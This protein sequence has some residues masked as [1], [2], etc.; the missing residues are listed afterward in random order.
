MGFIPSSS[1]IQLYAYFTE[2][3]RERIFNGEVSDFQV[4]QFSLHD[5]D[6][7][8]QISKYSLGQDSSG[9]TIYNIPKSGFI[10]DI[11]GDPDSCIKS[12]KN[13]IVFGKNMLT[14]TTQV[15]T[16]IVLGCTDP[17]ALNYDS[18]ATV[19]NGT[20]QYPPTPIRTLTIGFQDVSFKELGPPSNLKNHSYTF[21]VNLKALV[22]DTSGGPTLAESQATT[23]KIEILEFDPILVQNITIV[24]SNPITFI[25]G[26]VISCDL[27]F[28][29]SNLN[30]TGEPNYTEDA[31]IKIK[32]TPISPNRTVETGKGTFT[33]T[34]TLKWI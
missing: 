5:E 8:Y 19:N 30:P 23:F 32:I 22:G 26:G 12:N 4:T 2:Y 27:R 24:P 7:N 25:D 18:A 28:V 17:L 1:T 15:S 29:K 9:N 20:C 31:I 21:T 3:A 13:T 33:Y 14:G 11:T 16:P 34:K 6:I 10:P